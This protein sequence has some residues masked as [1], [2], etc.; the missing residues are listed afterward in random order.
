[1]QMTRERNR[2][3]RGERGMIS[4][5]Q[6]R[7]QSLRMRREQEMRAFVAG[8]LSDMLPG[9]MCLPLL[10]PRGTARRLS[11]CSLPLPSPRAFPTRVGSDV[12]RWKS[13]VMAPPP[14]LVELPERG[15]ADGELTLTG[16]HL[17]RCFSPRLARNGDSEY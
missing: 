8:Y 10:F 17:W 1:M 3:L 15:R 14:S 2:L 6:F 13:H 9:R 16:W 7:Y 4:S 11:P 12:T 5:A